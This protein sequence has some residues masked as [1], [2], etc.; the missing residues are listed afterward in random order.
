MSETAWRSVLNE[1]E[2]L[3]P[4]TR[5]G[6]ASAVPKD[7][8]GGSL[9][10]NLPSA[11]AR[12]ALRERCGE[13]LAAAARSAGYARVDLRVVD[14]KRPFRPTFASFRVTE[15]NQ[16]AYAAASSLALRLRPEVHPLLLQGSEGCGKSHLLTAIQDTSRSRGVSPVVATDPSRLCRRLGLAAKAG[17]LGEFRPWLRSCRIL[18]IDQADRLV[19]KTKT[20]TE[21]VH[22]LDALGCSGGVAVLAFRQPLGRLDGLSDHLNSRL[23]AG[24]WVQ[25]DVAS[26]V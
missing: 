13:A 24:L 21:L 10:L 25:M 15:G 26:R 14:A 20:Q 9:L 22:A 1:L 3:G 6:L 23:Q 5:A 19:G 17:K 7:G 12:D 2:S 11:F 8:P 18:L 16:L 4:S